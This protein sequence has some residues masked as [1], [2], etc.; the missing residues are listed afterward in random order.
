[1]QLMPA[2]AAAVAKSLGV[3]ADPLTD[4][5][6]NIRL[7]TTYLGRRVGELDG[8]PVL[9]TGAYNAGI[10]AVNA[11]WKGRCRRGTC[12]WKPCPYKETREYIARV[13]A[14]TVLYDWRIDGSPARLSGLIP[15][16]ADRAEPAPVACPDTAVA[17]IAQ[18]AASAR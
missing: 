14:F 5:A 8:N 2:T 15:G 7:G 6:H 13:L 11:G 12:G 17:M 16:L 3:R 9:A 10:G 4:P 1:M 18:E